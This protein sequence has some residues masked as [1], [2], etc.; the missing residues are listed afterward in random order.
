MFPLYS[1]D[2]GRI[3]QGEIN[4]LGENL[5]NKSEKE[6]IKLRN[7]SITCLPICIVG[8]KEVIGSWNIIEISLPRNLID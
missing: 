8:F 2:A 7:G 6:L 4:F 5:A 1:G 3:K